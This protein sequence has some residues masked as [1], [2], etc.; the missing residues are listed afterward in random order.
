MF[1]IA[2]YAPKLDEEP[3]ASDPTKKYSLPLKL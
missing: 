3:Y 1:D 2:E